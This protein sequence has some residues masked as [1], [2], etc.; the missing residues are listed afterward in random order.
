MVFATTAIKPREVAPGAESLRE[1]VVALPT[2]LLT[3]IPGLGLGEIPIFTNYVSRPSTLLPALLALTLIAGGAWLVVRR[4]RPRSRSLGLLML[5]G[6][7]VGAFPAV[8]GDAN[9][10]YFVVP[11]LLW[12]AAALVALDPLIRRSS[13]VAVGLVTAIIAVVWWPAFPAS[14]WRTTPAPDWRGEVE[15]VEAHCRADPALEERFVFTP[16]WPPNWGDALAEP[17]H[18]NVSCLTIWSAG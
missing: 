8:I 6:V 4:R 1:W 5:S 7:A 14:Q 15:R 9:N 12:A 3:F 13:P 10:R 11:C 18:P 16:F 17:S 2:A